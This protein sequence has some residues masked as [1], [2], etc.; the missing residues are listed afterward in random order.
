MT[1]PT[2][3]SRSAGGWLW[4][5]GYF[6][7]SWAMFKT[8]W[9]VLR[10]DRELLWLT[11][12]NLAVGLAFVL[13]AGVIVLV[14]GIIS[15]AGGLAGDSW[16]EAP[17]PVILVLVILLAAVG[18]FLSNTFFHGAIVHGA[19]ERLSGGDPTV[20]SAVAGARSR[21]GKLMLWG[22]VSL[23]IGVILSIIQK[24]L[25]RIPSV[26]WFLVFLVDLAWAVMKFLVLPIVIVEN[27]GP[28]ASLKRS[29]DLLKSTWGENLIANVSLWVMGFLLG[30][31]GFIGALPFLAIGR[32]L[33]FVPLMVVGGVLFVLYQV[34]VSLFMSALNSVWQSVLYHYAVKGEVPAGF[35]GQD[36]SEAFAPRKQRGLARNF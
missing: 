34:A 2:S 16:W 20:R 31:I 10:Q 18:I 27:R 30:I 13:V 36:L 22:L 19:L 9:H 5:P 21:F 6:R 3:G 14:A 29:K 12:I 4:R 35:E 33:D 24:L 32:S 23:T 25:E 17:H 26:G 7:R 8:S 28:F 1:Y 15:S 11:V